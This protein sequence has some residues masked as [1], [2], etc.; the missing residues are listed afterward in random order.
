MC[1]AFRT[2]FY[3]LPYSLTLFVNT[4]RMCI[5]HEMYSLSEHLFLRAYTKLREGGGDINYIKKGTYTIPFEFQLPTSLPSSTQY[6]FPKNQ[7]QIGK[8]YNCRIQYALIATL[9][10]GDCGDGS[11]RNR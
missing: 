8:V 1:I 5:L 2:R 4:K 10:G 3:T 6:P 9:G 11:S 7:R